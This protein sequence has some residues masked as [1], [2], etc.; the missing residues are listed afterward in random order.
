VVVARSTDVGVPDRGCVRHSRCGEGAIEPVVQDRLDRAVGG[1]ADLVAAPGRRLDALRSKLITFAACPGA[2]LPHYV[3]SVSPDK[4]GGYKTFSLEPHTDIVKELV[5]EQ[6]DS[7]RAELK[8]RLAKK[9]EGEP[10]GDFPVPPS[11]QPDL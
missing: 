3:G 4:F 5:A 10:I 1:R 7:T 11:P 8:A 6:P 2:R 9:S